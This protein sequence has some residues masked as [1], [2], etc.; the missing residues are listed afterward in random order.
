MSPFGK[1][2][3]VE[4]RAGPTVLALFSLLGLSLSLV[5]CSIVKDRP[6]QLMSDTA[7]ALKA[8]REVSADTLAPEKYRQATEAFLRAQNE[9]RFKN[10]LIA[11][12]FALRAKKWAEESEFLALNQGSSRNSL[13]PPDVPMGPPA[14]SS[15]EPPQGELATEA[16]KR[17]AV[18]PGGAASTPNSPANPMTP[19]PQSF[20]NFAP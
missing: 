3:N 16:M 4:K 9:Y 5:A 11:E 7:A 2:K 6:V 8:A 1:I 12:D 20:P 18:A 19:A 14:P 13:L 17:P 10:F 15:Y